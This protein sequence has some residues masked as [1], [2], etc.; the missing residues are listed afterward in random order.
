MQSTTEA[1]PCRLYYITDRT[2]FP[3]SEP[4]RR[5]RLLQKVEEAAEAGVDY[6]QLR[7]KDLPTRDL[8]I[9][10]RRVITAIRTHSSSI[11]GYGLAGT[12]LLINSRTD[13]AMA[14][15]ADGVHLRSDDI[16]SHEARK[17]WNCACGMGA[18]AREAGSDSV[19]NVAEPSTQIATICNPL[20]AVSCHSIA[21]V[22]LAEKEAADFAVFGPVFKKK[23]APKTAL[24]GLDT[25]RE[26]CRQKIPVFALGGVTLENAHACLRAGATGIA[27][28]RLF[29]ENDV[30]K[31][32][33]RLRILSSHLPG[34]D[35]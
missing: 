17:I 16:S 30:R 2:Q 14:V 28:I 15:G 31:V 35:N 20:I 13:V 19:L 10:A 21:E 26:A 1:K 4:Q 18:L 8:E 6:I 29:Q 12:R 11:P 9:L 24:S 27:A 25:L 34:F 7:E 5:S 33:T 22:L 23:D 32:V 3:G